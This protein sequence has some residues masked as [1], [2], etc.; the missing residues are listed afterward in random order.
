MGDKQNNR[1]EDKII[2]KEVKNIQG[3]K[4]T[5]KEIK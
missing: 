3:D 1:H 2:F 4:I 5:S